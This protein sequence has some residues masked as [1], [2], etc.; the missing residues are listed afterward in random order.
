MTVTPIILGTDVSIN[1]DPIKVF[2][3]I[4]PALFPARSFIVAL[5]FGRVIV[6]L[7][8]VKADEESSSCTTV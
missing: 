5:T 7:A 4:N 3:W 2:E 8:R 6:L 1:A